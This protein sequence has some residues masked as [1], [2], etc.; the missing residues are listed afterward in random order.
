MKTRLLVIVGIAISAVLIYAYAIYDSSTGVFVDCAPHY[1]QVDGKCIM[2]TFKILLDDPI[3]PNDPLIVSVEKTG[4]RMCDEWSAG[5][6]DTANNSTVWEKDYRTL[7]VVESTLKQQKFI[8]EIS[9]EINPILINDVGRYLFQIDIGGKMLE[10]EFR[11]LNTFGGISLDR[12]VYPDGQFCADE[13]DKMYHKASEIPCSCC[14]PPPGEPVCEPV[15]LEGHIRDMVTEEFKPCV[16]T[17]DR[18]A[19][20]TENNDS[21][22]YA[23]G[24]NYVKLKMT[25]TNHEENIPISITFSGYS[26][27]LNDFHLIIK[28]HIMDGKV[29]F[30]ENYDQVCD[31]SKPNNEFKTYREINL[32]GIGKPIS[33]QKGQY[34]IELYTETPQKHESNYV[35]KVYFSSHYQ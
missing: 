35:D 26:Q 9:N 4:Y 11:V 17:V 22:W 18:W 27:C 30:E 29:V 25:K 24:T 15:P 33:L 1:E 28:E 31:E 20:L 32:E 6:T 2:P 34:V 5:I 23:F 13:F 14:N 7:C 3:H 21:A 19:Y 16:G 8:Y 12:T 10:E